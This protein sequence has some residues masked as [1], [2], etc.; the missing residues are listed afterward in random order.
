M[1]GPHVDGFRCGSI[2]F[3]EVRK[4]NNVKKENMNLNENPLLVE[5][6]FPLFDRIA[7][8][9]VVPAMRQVLD[10]ANER[11]GWLEQNLEPT[12]AGLIHPLE[13][14]N[15]PFEYSWGVVSHLM[16]VKNSDELRKAHDQVLA[17]V[18]QFGLRVNQSPAIFKGLL[19]LRNGD[20][21]QTF[22]EAQRRIVE[23]KIR[24][25]KHAGVGLSGEARQRFNAIAEELSQLQTD[26]SNHLLD[27]TKAFEFILT[28][29][30]EILGWPET[31]KQF[32][33]QSW[34]S[35]NKSDQKATADNGPW[36]IT[37]DLPSYI[38]FMEHHC[39]RTHREQ[40]YRAYI[41]RASVG[42]FDNSELIDRI[43]TLRKEKA[44]LLGFDNYADFS[45]DSKMAEG[46]AAV[47]KMFSELVQAARQPSRKEL[48]ELRQLA[49][50]SGQTEPLAHWDVPFWAERLREKRFEFTDEQL[51]PYFPL[52]R[53]IEGLFS[54]CSWLF[55]VAFEQAD[56]V[57]P[58]WHEDVH[59]YRVKNGGGETIA[60]FYLDPY[61]RPAEKRGGAWMDSCLDRCY[62][63][64]KLRHPVVH[65]C[66]NGTPPTDSRPSLMSFSE[67]KTLF[68]E[69]GHGLQG[70]LTTI[71]YGDAAGI[72]GIEW[73]A[74]EVASQF[75]ENWCYHKQ[76]LIEMTAHIDTGETLP[77]A[78]FD[79]ICA[80]RTF[81]AGSMFTR[82]LEFGMTDMALHT[83]FDPNGEASV[84]DVHQQ[85]ARDLNPLPPLPES[86]F[87][88]SFSHIFAGGYAAG[89]YSYKWAEVLS[90]DAFAAFEE[91]GLD[92]Q[93]AIA[94][95][96]RRFRDTILACGGGRDPM[97]VFQD[98]RGRAPSTDAL[99]KHSGLK[100]S[101]SNE[102]PN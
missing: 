84:F 32:A 18:V 99:L 73:D 97:K 11:I 77:D 48:D 51:R 38:P 49:Q 102:Q 71:D 6:G 33:A 29:T 45:L 80:A 66:C 44:Q 27:A 40:V 98:F 52:P 8:E 50:A 74:V 26:F 13:Q 86:R 101:S 39:N 68:H 92:N 43:L 88:C 81:R 42:E 10:H 34:N 35:V 21:W 9:H 53:V 57:A 28:E 2:P 20:A 79:K 61:S 47:Q 22:D 100:G 14:V 46:M 83:E 65:L 12:W 85:I 1:A 25:A 91:V 78:L 7:P 24:A 5:T 19:D 93:A 63:E 90:A 3:T 67:V 87:L 41:Q 75:M 70:M 4:E 58:V 82:Q 62:I 31:L 89:Y 30:R 94:K 56:G 37:L 59:F 69:F 15:I 76:T 96:G 16:G 55:G 23:Y 60:W 17:D 72:N 95:L 54:L 64:G 36:R